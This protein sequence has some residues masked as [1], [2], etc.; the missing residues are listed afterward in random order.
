MTNIFMFLQKITPKQDFCWLFS[1][2]YYFLVVIVIGYSESALPFL[3]LPVADLKLT[4]GRGVEGCARATTVGVAP[5]TSPFPKTRSV[6][7]PGDALKTRWLQFSA[8]QQNSTKMHI[9]VG[10]EGIITVR[11]VPNAYTRR[12]RRDYYNQNCTKT[13]I[14]VGEQ[15]QQ[16]PAKVM[17]DS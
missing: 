13:R 3:L 16:H 4:A 2:N 6:C 8:S 1:E 7:A 12:G 10:P 11:T 15:A 17:K 5:K 9:L 14:L